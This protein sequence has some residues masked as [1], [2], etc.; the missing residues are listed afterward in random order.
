[1]LTGGVGAGS[2]KDQLGIGTAPERQGRF[3]RLLKTATMG[4][5]H[6]ALMLVLN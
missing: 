2:S 3:V 5:V 4:G 1:M 6:S